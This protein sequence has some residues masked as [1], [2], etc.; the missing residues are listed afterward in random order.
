[1]SQ[2]NPIA[3]V[4]E[5]VYCQD[6]EKCF[7]DIFVYEPENVEEKAL[8][9]LFIIGELQDLPRDSA[10][11]INLLASKIKKEF[12]V[13]RKRGTEASLE[14]ALVEANNVLD[15]MNEQGNEEYVG[16]LN[17]ACGACKDRMFFISQVG[18]MQ[19]MLIRGERASEVVNARS[20][21]SSHMFEN[22]A[23]GELKDRDLIIIGTPKIFELFSIKKLGEM[24]KDNDINRF[25]EQIQESIEEHKVELASAFLMQMGGSAAADQED[26]NVVKTVVPSS[27][28]AEA[29]EVI[30]PNLNQEVSSSLE[31]SG[32]SSAETE[33]PLEIEKPTPVPL[34]PDSSEK[35]LAALLEEEKVADTFTEDLAEVT[36]SASTQP[37]LAATPQKQQPLE[38]LIKEFEKAENPPAKSSAEAATEVTPTETA[39]APERETAEVNRNSPK[40]LPT[41]FLNLF[42]TPNVAMPGLL[43]NLKRKPTY[44]L[45]NESR[46]RQLSLLPKKKFALLMGALILITVG[47]Y[48][49]LKPKSAPVDT[50]K[51]QYES[52]LN[53]AQRKLQKAQVDTVGQNDNAVAGKTLLEALS[54]AQKV[55]SEY[56]A[57]AGDADN[58]I[59]ESQ[60][61]LDRLDKVANVQSPTVLVEFKNEGKRKLVMTN[62]VNYI[63][64]LETKELFKPDSAGTLEKLKTIDGFN[65][66]IVALS[67]FGA[68]EIIITDGN[69]L[70]SFNLKTDQL[71]PLD[72]ETGGAFVNLRAY[73]SNLYFLSNAQEQIFKTAKNG[74]KL[75]VPVTW[76]KGSSPYLQNAVDLAIDSNLFILNAEGKIY[77]FLSG[78]EWIDETGKNFTPTP[79]IQPIKAAFKI[80]TE[81]NYKYIYIAEPNRILLFDKQT[82][83]LVKQFKGERLQNIQDFAVDAKEQTITFINKK[84]VLSF[85]L[86]S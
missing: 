48:M 25:A 52:L 6:A 54:L 51:Q 3:E 19:S 64:D 39:N 2:K 72:G 27:Q 21:K 12:Y 44:A 11:V 4:R 79:P 23:S 42:K 63:F 65:N 15:D 86:N 55:K 77:K 16:K 67:S 73:G 53:E 31:E 68:Q 57:L 29:E 17:M 30:T 45:Q 60:K 84:A 43:K 9:T 33:K 14:A 69:T 70:S 76:L 20:D 38:D 5:I 83:N 37:S 80:V 74:N 78:K 34:V 49:T 10:Y 18:K 81:T 22:I 28:V 8:G 35:S 24:Y 46:A 56:G 50:R 75:G 7:G 66:E 36:T 82:G 59:T 26:T 40:T 13:D 62:D 85:H 58:I 47:A 32:D 1:M 71:A 61:E 41:K